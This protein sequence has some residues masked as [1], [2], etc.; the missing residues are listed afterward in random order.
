[1]KNEW[2][3]RTEFGK[4]KRTKDP[5]TKNEAKIEPSLRS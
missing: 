1:V 4:M 5:K 2:A 3:I